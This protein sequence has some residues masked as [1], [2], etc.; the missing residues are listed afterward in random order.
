VLFTEVTVGK[1]VARLTIGVV[2]VVTD[3]GDVPETDATL[4]FAVV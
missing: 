2:P 4:A 3:I 1:V